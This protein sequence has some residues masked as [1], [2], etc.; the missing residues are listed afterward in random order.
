MFA[1]VSLNAL[2][3]HGFDS[4]IDVRSP[5]EF[6]EDHLPGAL[7]LPVLNDEERAR[8]GTIYKQQSP[9]R[10]RKIGAALVF[11]NAA[12]HIETALADR[13]GGWRP[14][15]YCWRGGQRSGS[16]SWMLREIG[17]RADTLE[18]GYKTFR[19]F[20]T[21]LL[22]ESPLPYRLVQLGGYTGTGKT[23]LL[24][25]LH[26]LGVQII[27]LEG[28]ARHR[29]SL[30]GRLDE[31][32][33]GQKAF[34]SALATALV[35]L[36]PARPV[37]LEAESSRIGDLALPPT[38]WC[39]MKEA[40]WI[41]VDA[42]LEA[43]AGYLARVYH[44]VLADHIELKNKLEPLRQH[45]GHTVVN[46]WMDLIDARDHLALCRA[47]AHEHYD[48]A[49]DKSVRKHAPRVAAR[50]ES[51]DLSETALDA[52][53]QRIAAAFQR[54]ESAPAGASVIRPTTAAL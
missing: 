17:W 52:A 39:A 15:V 19:R 34:E 31:P 29:G 41:V 26:H 25:R 47:L 20:V 46:R 5:A 27:D 9:F 13:D 42:P 1:P 28:L 2:S 10:A 51:S 54:I 11:R 12:T 21:D 36:D 45:R 40:P 24:H 50:I 8:V 16:F 18:G 43:R 4:L 49:Y 23:A 44:S 33:P 7:N 32:Q 48:P 35:S 37:L 14:L 3:N 53:S 22:Y 6:A 38:L 30:L